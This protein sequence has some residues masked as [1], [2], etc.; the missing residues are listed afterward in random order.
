MNIAAIYF[1]QFHSFPNGRVIATGMSSLFNTLGPDQNA[2]YFA[3]ASFKSILSNEKFHITLQF[4]LLK[5][6]SEDP[7]EL[8]NIEYLSKDAS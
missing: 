5:S 7:G 3:D 2:Q 4:F 1:P 6:A 8:C